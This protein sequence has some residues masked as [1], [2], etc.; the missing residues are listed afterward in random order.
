GPTQD[1]ASITCKASGV[2]TPWMSW[3]NGSLGTTWTHATCGTG[4]TRW[5]F[6]LSGY[7]AH[8]GPHILNFKS[9]KK[10]SV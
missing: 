7:L 1:A 8:S 6:E 10:W 2:A 9:G 3:T 5:T 4:R